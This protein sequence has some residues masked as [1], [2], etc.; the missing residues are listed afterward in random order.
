MRI[1]LIGP[2]LAGAALAAALAGVPGMQVEAFEEAPAPPGRGLLLAP[3]ALRALRLHLP[4]HHAAVRATAAPWDSLAAFRADGV[5]FGLQPML[6]L[7]GEPG[8]R[9]SL[10][11]LGAALPLPAD[12]RFGMR[13][14]ALEQ[15]AAARLVP[16]LAAPDGAR[17]RPR[18]FDLLVAGRGARLR[19][20]VA[21]EAPAGP[22]GIILARLAVPAARRLPF[23]DPAEWWGEGARLQAWA[24]PGEAA[25]MEVIL[26][27]AP[28][29][30]PPSTV[31]ASALRQRLLPDQGA[32][33]AAVAWALEWLAAGAAGLG[34]GP[35]PDL[36]L[37]RTAAGGRVLFLGPA[38]QGLAPGLGQAESLAIEDGVVAAAVL[39]R[40]GGAE[41]VAAWRNTR[42]QFARALCGEVLAPIL[43]PGPEP[44]M[45]P[46]QAARL[47]RLFTDIPGP[48]D[49]AG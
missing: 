29:Q 19:R 40:G 1:G 38:A 14:V 41:D 30:A 11:A 25:V 24:L 4:A 46:A 48:E 35:P 33:C 5:P 16:V 49:F 44:G 18:G 39:R 27:L 28:G 7:A 13:L 23:A 34:W 32:P 9:L 15:D 26:A 42:A 37:R 10:G 36:P 3:N 21:P 8:A 43:G 6:A 2:G 12:T 45:D 47:R 22:S 31:P 20:L 17:L